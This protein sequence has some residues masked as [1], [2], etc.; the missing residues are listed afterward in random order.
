[1]SQGIVCPRKNQIWAVQLFKHFAAS[2]KNV[3]LVIVGCRYSR[4][5]EIDYI[6][7]LKI[8]I[9]GDVR[10]ELHDV[11]ENVQ[12]FYERAHVLLFTSLNEVTPMVISEAMSYGLPVIATSIAGMIYFNTSLL[13]P[14][15]H[16]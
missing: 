10:I 12:F 2:S 15:R 6:N 16:S 13:N 14:L 1:M 5:Y 9:A 11:T 3:K 4:K 7:E 8:A